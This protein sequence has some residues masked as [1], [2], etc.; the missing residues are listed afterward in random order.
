M[1]RP[2]RGRQLIALRLDPDLLELV[3]GETDDRSET[4]RRIIREHYEG[5]PRARRKR[6][7]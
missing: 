5:R 3:D 1:P 7:A 6:A 2:N 4:L